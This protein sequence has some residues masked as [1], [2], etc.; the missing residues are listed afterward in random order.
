[1]NKTIEIPALLP[2]PKI[3][4]LSDIPE[5]LNRICYIIEVYSLDG[6]GVVVSRDTGDICFRLCDFSGKLL[7]PDNKKYHRMFKIIFEKFMPRLIQTMQIISIAKGQFYFSCIESPILVDLRLSLN[8]FCSP[9]YLE[10][11]FGRQGLLVQKSVGK[12]ILLDEQNLKKVRDGVGIYESGHFIIKP[13]TF[14]SIIRGDEVLPMYGVLNNEA[15][16]VT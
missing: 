3:Y 10:D 13:S 1:M 8:K 9:G 5:I 11:I 15:Q 4:P 16:S 7:E 6:V 2:Y 12:P 14:K